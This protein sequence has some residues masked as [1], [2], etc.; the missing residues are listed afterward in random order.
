MGSEMLCSY[1]QKLYIS[2]IESQFLLY[3]MRLIELF[4]NQFTLCCLITTNTKY[5]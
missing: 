2:N 1:V 4:D 3:T 5:F